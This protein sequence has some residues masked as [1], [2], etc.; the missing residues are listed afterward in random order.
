M[1]QAANRLKLPDVIV[2]PNGIICLQKMVF[3]PDRFQFFQGWSESIGPI[4]TLP[5]GPRRRRL[6]A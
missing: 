2:Q 4:N 5:N 3:D 6:K 1:E